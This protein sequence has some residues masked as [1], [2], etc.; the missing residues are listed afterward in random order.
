L[1]GILSTLIGWGFVVLGT[2]IGRL[3][4]FCVVT[5][6]VTALGR[7]LGDLLFYVLFKGDL[8]CAYEKLDRLRDANLTM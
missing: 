1:T 7:F 2:G 5:L 8:R 4:L 3:V 6:V